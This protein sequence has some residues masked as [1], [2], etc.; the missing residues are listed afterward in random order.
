MKN[1]HP[2][3]HLI[4]KIKVIW[5]KLHILS[6]MSTQPDDLKSIFSII[7]LINNDGNLFLAITSQYNHLS[8][9][10]PPHTIPSQRFPSPE[11]PAVLSNGSL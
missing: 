3:S 8:W 2:V 7:L 10:Q 4:E 1:Q 5:Q 9:S 11:S 6:K